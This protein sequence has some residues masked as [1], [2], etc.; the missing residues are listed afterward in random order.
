MSKSKIMVCFPQC[1]TNPGRAGNIE[2]LTIRYWEAMLSGCVII[3]RAPNELI[4]LIGYNP[5]I[6]VDWERAQEQ[7][8][9]ILFCIENFSVVS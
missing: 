4:N 3:G 9:E 6:E 5:V 8:E 7:L 2:T 1:D